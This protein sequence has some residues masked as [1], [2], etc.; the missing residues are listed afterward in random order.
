MNCKLQLITVHNMTRQQCSRCKVTL[1]IDNFKLKRSGDYTKMCIQCLDNA[2]ITREKYKCF[3]GK[4]NGYCR[5]CHGSQ[6]CEHD[7]RRT[8]CKICKG[9][10]LCIHGGRRNQCKQCSPDS[11]CIHGAQ[12][13]QCT[14][15]G[16]TSVCEHKRVRSRCKE[17]KGGSVCEHGKIR[18]ICVQCDGGHICEH[19]KQRSDC[20]ECD[21]IAY[22]SKRARTR[23]YATLKRNKV[24]S[25]VDYLG[26]NMDT[27]R[28]YIEEQFSDGMSWENYGEWHID[29]RAY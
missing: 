18:C 9:G 27:Y 8:T 11:F 19:K 3:H 14:R 26:C 13:S 6:F 29:H 16:G 10:S 17:C 20:R 23:V 1:D 28:K 4:H 22:F 15:C 2:K 25:T 21:F 24:K 5:E 12:R 7:K